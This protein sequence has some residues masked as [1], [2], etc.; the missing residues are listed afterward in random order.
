MEFSQMP[1]DPIVVILGKLDTV[2]E[3]LK[4]CQISKHFNKLIRTSSWQ[5]VVNIQHTLTDTNSEIVTYRSRPDRA[6]TIMHTDKTIDNQR[7]PGF[8]EKIKYIMK[9]YLFVN[10]HFIH[11]GYDGDSKYKICTLGPTISYVAKC[12]EVVLDHCFILGKD[13]AILAECHTVELFNCEGFDN[14]DIEHLK[15]CSKVS[16]LECDNLTSKC[17]QYLSECPIVRL[18]IDNF[19]E[20][21]IDVE[22]MKYLSNCDNISLFHWKTINIDVE[23]LTKCR[24]VMLFN[25]PITAEGLASLANC[26]TVDINHCYYIKDIHSFLPLARCRTVIW[27]YT[28]ITEEIRKLKEL[29]K[30]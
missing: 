28:N 12:Q 6:L 2:V 24:K 7:Q 9:N 10:Y 15:K 14:D 3:L 4:M 27:N 25:C 17:F 21:K 11:W 26:D 29:Q 1:D 5:Q 8:I 20:K 23:Y 18:E 30:S 13:L 22:D 16:L 19:D